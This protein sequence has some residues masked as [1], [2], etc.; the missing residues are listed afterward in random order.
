MI[1]KN[2][3]LF[4]ESDTPY[5][6]SGSKDDNLFLQMEIDCINFFGTYRISVRMIFSCSTVSP[7]RDQ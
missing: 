6:M 3:C 5:G 7:A 1:I 4:L 2:I